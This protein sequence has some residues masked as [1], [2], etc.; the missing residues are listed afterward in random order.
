MDIRM[1]GRH[2][3]ITDPIRRYAISKISR[4]PR[5]YDRVA[6]VDVI[7]DQH[8]HINDVEIIVHVD[9]TKPFIGRS[10][11]RDLYA[12]IDNA[13]AKLERQLSEFKK[14]LRNYKHSA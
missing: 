10:K 12:C 11:G 4:L 7:A 9:G 13:V 14:K 8:G 6:N 1:A 5:Y 3:K 2:L